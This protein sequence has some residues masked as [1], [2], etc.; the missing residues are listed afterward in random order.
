MI[1]T[2]HNAFHIISN[3]K[4]VLGTPNQN[5]SVFFAVLRSYSRYMGVLFYPTKC[6]DIFAF[7]FSE[8]VFIE[9]FQYSDWQAIAA[10]SN[11]VD[12]N[13]FSNKAKRPELPVLNSF[14]DLV[15]CLDNFLHLAERIFIVEV[16]EEVR[17]IATFLR[18]NQ[19]NISSHGANI[20]EPLTLWT[21]QLLFKLRVALESSSAE[22]LHEFRLAIHINATDFPSVIPGALIATVRWLESLHYQDN[23]MAQ[24]LRGVWRGATKRKSDGPDFNVVRAGIPAHNGKEGL[25]W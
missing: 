7:E 15:A 14:G 9:E 4:S 16:V 19:S 20:V 11:S 12:M 13:D 24:G 23:S 3:G 22:Q 17:R 25:P 2:Q 1:E 21:N 5:P 6:K 8:A 10:Q 18:R